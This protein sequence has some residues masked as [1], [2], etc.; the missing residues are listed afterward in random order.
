VGV[1]ERG[2]R[3]DRGGTAARPALRQRGDDDGEGGELLGAGL[4]LDDSEE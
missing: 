2:P 1:A 3:P 4:A